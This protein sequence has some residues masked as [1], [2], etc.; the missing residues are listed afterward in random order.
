MD[1]PADRSR[2]VGLVL[3]ATAIATIALLL[4]HPAE[5]ATDFPGVLK[6]EAANQLLNGIVHG[7][8]VVVLAIQLACYAIFSGRI[9]W[10]RS[11]A[12]AGIVFFAIGAA[13]QMA[14][15]T[16]D[17]LMIPQLAARYL[18]APPDRLPFVRSLFVLCGTAN[19]FLMPMGLFFQGVGVAAWGTSLVR[20]ARGAGLSGLLVGSMVMAAVIGAAVAGAMHLMMIAIALLALWALIAGVTL[21]QRTI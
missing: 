3:M 9:G 13:I 14:S 10:Q 17:G 16:V 11:F 21:F 19:Q 12:I 1:N 2:G 4:N 15:L 7:G 20:I 6:E 5:Q 8:F 18:A